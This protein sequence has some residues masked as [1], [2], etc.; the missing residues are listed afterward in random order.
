MTVTDPRF[1]ERYRALKSRD[2]RFDGQFI[3]GVHSTGIYCRPSCPA[4]T[5][6]E[7]NV[8]FFRTA[9]AAHE[10]GLRACKRCQP[11]AVPGSPDWNI[12]DDIA[13]RAMR[14]ITDGV[15]EREGVNGLAARLG[16]TSRHVTRVLTTELGAGP[17]SLARAHRAQS[18]RTLLA[19][20]EIS[21]ADVAFAAGFSS[22]RQFNDTIRAVYE[23]SPSELRSL[24]RRG[25]AATAPAAGGADHTGTG[26][27]LSLRLPA[28]AP[29]DGPGLM[30]YFADHAVPGLEDADGSFFERAVRLPGGIARV[31][32]ELDGPSAIWVK[33]SLDSIGDV[34]A[35]VAR[36]RRLFDLDADSL[37][38]DAALGSDRVLGRL[39]AALP[40]IRLPGAVDAEEALFRTLIGQQISVAAARTVLGR[41]TR[42]LGE[43]GAFPTALQLAE[44]GLEVLRGPA[45]RVATIVGAARAICEGRV[46][47]DIGAPV[48]EFTAQLTA[49]PGIGVWTAGYL[50]IRVLGNPDVLLATDLVMAQSAASH[51][52]PSRPRE[53]A[54]YARAWAP[55]RSYAGMHLWR[56]RPK[57]QS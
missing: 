5:P 29:F 57:A 41:L 37:A 39:V 14:L 23:S 12:T 32:L 3:A 25:R 15:V 6:L 50:A 22:I 13:A 36:V 20:T 1:A 54:D 35:L 4:I 17:V 31:R 2:S 34:G 24:G 18:A 48:D 47:L 8:S 46:R 30:T 55:W 27:A 21:V 49:L 43:G 38:I 28:R 16:Y 19:S 10:V 7:R 56:S 26:T 44:H 33:A 11:D 51:G 52:L 42:D 40:G 9:A 53:L 45:S